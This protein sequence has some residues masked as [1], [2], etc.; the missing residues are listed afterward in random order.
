MENK[1]V[2]R[3]NTNQLSVLTIVEIKIEN[4]RNDI[5]KYKIKQTRT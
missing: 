1:I 4:H 5:K 2:D 3:F